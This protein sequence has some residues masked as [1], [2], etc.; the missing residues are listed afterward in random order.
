[1]AGNSSTSTNGIDANRESTE[2]SLARIAAAVEK[3]N[4][5]QEGKGKEDGAEE[6][7]SEDEP[8]KPGKAKQ[9]F[10]SPLGILITLGVVILL[11]IGAVSL[12]QYESTHESTDDAY[13]A[14]HV[15]QISPRVAGM[16]QEVW[17]DDNQE[18][19]AGALLVKLDPHDYQ[20][21]L[22]QAQAALDQARAQVIAAQS[23]IIQ[24]Q[25]DYAQAQ[26]QA[27]E[28]AAKF[29]IAVINYKRNKG[30]FTKDVRAVAEEDVD[31][32]YSDVAASKG[33]LDAAN[34]SV[35]AAK[36][37]I[38]SRQAQLSVAEAGVETN[39]AAVAKARLDLSYCWILAPAD[40]RVSR[41]TVETGQQL[42]AGQALM[43]VTE[44]DIWVLANFKETQLS[45]LR[46]GQPVK[47][48][49]DAFKD[50]PFTGR[51]DS[52]QNGTGATY[53]LLPPDNATGNFTKIVQ[54]VPVK[55]TFDRES[56]KGYEN[57]IV[58]GLSVVPVVDLSGA[59][60]TQPQVSKANLAHTGG[61][62]RQ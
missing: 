43:A 5:R 38:G 1:M 30:L 29:Q 35:A 32:T 50:H 58:P 23:A 34:A 44:D 56:I 7:K 61:L 41:K 11:I 19:K 59:S 14:G 46:V 39:E 9:F 49:I 57:L 24:A 37:V 22:Q 48:P 28:S 60:D 52:I 53:S 17:V 10:R 51:V 8:K 42:S 6:K 21:A 62:P 47:L 13:T 33:A 36:S 40:G 18:V 16:V 20:V 55:L 26:A 15:H 25:A 12:W 54:R 45:G 31:T 27:A 3:L 4:E 2:D